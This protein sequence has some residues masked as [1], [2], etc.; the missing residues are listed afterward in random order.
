MDRDNAYSKSENTYSD[1]QSGLRA[2][3]KSLVEERRRVTPTF[4][5]PIEYISESS[6][7]FRYIFTFLRL[8]SLFCKG[9]QIPCKA[10]EALAAVLAYA[11]AQNATALIVERHRKDYSPCHK[12]AR[13]FH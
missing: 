2:K 12:G 13:C 5:I 10:L 3:V 9:S 6:S 11:M 4:F 8:H 7:L 1:L